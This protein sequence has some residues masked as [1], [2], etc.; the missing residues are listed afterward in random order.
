MRQLEMQ[1]R[2][3]N[4]CRSFAQASALIIHMLSAYP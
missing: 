2:S 4:D 3:K 1:A